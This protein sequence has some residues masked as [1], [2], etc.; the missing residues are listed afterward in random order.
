MGSWNVN[1]KWKESLMDWKLFAKAINSII[2]N[3]FAQRTL[4]LR[5]TSKQAFDNIDLVVEKLCDNAPKYV[6]MISNTMEQ[7]DAI[8][9]SAPIDVDNNTNAE[10]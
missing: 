6:T 2:D 1:Q 4:H 9:H 5:D 7:I 3:F 10:A 8:D